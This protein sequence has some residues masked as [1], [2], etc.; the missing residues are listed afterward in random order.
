[1]IAILGSML[2]VSFCLIELGVRR[3]RHYRINK[4]GHEDFGSFGRRVLIKTIEFICRLVQAISF[5][6]ALLL[7]F[8]YVFPDEI[9]TGLRSFYQAFGWIRSNI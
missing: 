3:S 6:C 2:L 7:I 4:F 1:M 9:M 5:V 8:Y